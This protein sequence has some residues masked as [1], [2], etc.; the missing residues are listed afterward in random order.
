MPR[1]GDGMSEHLN[2]EGSLLAEVGASD[3]RAFETIVRHYFP[4]LLP[5]AIKITK[6]K[7][8]A[9]DIVQEAFLRLWQHRAEYE[10]ILF[11]RAWL[12]TVVSNLSLTYIKRLAREG[13]LLQHLR[14]FSDT[15]R[16]DVAEQLQFRES[17]NVIA[18]AVDRL[19]PQQ[20]QIYRL[21]RYEGL[22]IPEIAARLQLSPNTVKNHLVRA[23][24]SVRDFVRKAGLF[25]F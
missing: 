16:S 20:Q 18:R 8:V 24:Q 17:G 19:P 15:A 7:A 9:E 11:L 22:S 25:W 6:N 23:L 13:K 4:R 1:E 2:N 3:E 21:S 14:D 5:F 12:F 10:K